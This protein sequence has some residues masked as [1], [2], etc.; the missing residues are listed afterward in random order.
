MVL[1]RYCGVAV[2]C[3]SVRQETGTFGDGFFGIAEPSSLFAG[4]TTEMF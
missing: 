2:K 4:D 1:P 3:L